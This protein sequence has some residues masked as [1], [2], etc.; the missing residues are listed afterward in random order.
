MDKAIKGIT[1]GKAKGPQADKEKY[2]HPHRMPFAYS[3]Q[4]STKSLTLKKA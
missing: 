4:L 1:V 3:R 2:N